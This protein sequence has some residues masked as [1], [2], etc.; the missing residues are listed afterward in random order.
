MAI[1]QCSSVKRSCVVHGT[2]LRVMTGASTYFQAIGNWSVRSFPRLRPGSG[3]HASAAR[4]QQFLRQL[5]AAN[6]ANALTCRFLAQPTQL[7]SANAQH[8]VRNRRQAQAG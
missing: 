5:L 1:A 4:P 2:R 6:N 7:E 3:D 8:G